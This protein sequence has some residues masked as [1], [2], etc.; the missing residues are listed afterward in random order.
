MRRLLAAGALGILTTLTFPAQAQTWVR[1]YETKFPH[2][3]RLQS[4]D[5]LVDAKSVV[6]QGKYVYLNLK[7]EVFD[8]NGKRVPRITE[9]GSTNGNGI[10]VNCETKQ[11]NQ[12][13]PRGWSNADGSEVFALIVEFA[14]R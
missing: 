9:R 3:S 8:R 2:G 4:I 12:G 13:G 14:C 7:I 1:L 6:R 10:Q 11:T 5:W